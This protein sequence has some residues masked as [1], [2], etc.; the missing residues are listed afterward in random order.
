MRRIAR[1]D[2]D[3]EPRALRRDVEEQPAVLDLEKYKAR[4][5]KVKI[6]VVG[7][8]NLSSDIPP[9]LAVEVIEALRIYGIFQANAD[10]KDALAQAGII[11]R[12]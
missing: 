5:E 2:G 9:T 3:V 7:L 6:S 12:M 8:C 1:F 10:V 4:N 11:K